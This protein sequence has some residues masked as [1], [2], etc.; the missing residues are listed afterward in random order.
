MNLTEARAAG[1]PQYDGGACDLCGGTTRFTRTKRC[2]ACD[3]PA[4]IPGEPAPQY[5]TLT[6]LT[7]TDA[8][9]RFMPRVPLETVFAW[10][11]KGLLSGMIIPVQEMEDLAAT[12]PSSLAA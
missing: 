1:E 8:A 3:Q 12:L 10:K 6:Y 5:K 2:V 11:D 7:L 9:K 4:A